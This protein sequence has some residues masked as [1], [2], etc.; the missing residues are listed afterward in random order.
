MNHLY[1]DTSQAFIILGLYIEGIFYEKILKHENKMGTYLANSIKHFIEGHGLKIENLQ[2]I[3]CGVGPGSYTGTRVGVAFAQSL[4]FGLDLTLKKVPSL[5]FF[6]NPGESHLAICSN[7]DS[8]GYL[9]LKE[10]TY[11]FNLLNKND[12][13]KTVRILDPK[14]LT[15]SP[16]WELIHKLKCP[17]TLT[18]LLYFTLN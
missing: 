10:D 11:T 16:N 3:T 15:P 12:L 5:V 4:A 8:C 17:K 6:L 13:N 9:E 2:N 18:E 1:I 14:N 7:F